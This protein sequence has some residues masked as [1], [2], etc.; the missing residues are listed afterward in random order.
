MKISDILKS[1]GANLLR[2]KG[3]TILTV[4][5]IFIGAFTISLTTGVNTGVNDYIDKQVSSVGGENQLFVQPKMETGMESS[6]GPAEYNPEQASA[7]MEYLSNRDLDK[8]KEKKGI[9][10]AE[11][12]MFLSTDYIQGTGDKK[13]VFSAATPSEI[14]IDLEAGKEVTSTG[15]AY[16]LNLAPEYLESLGYKKAQDAI[17][18]IVRIAV[19]SQATGEQEILEAKI[20]GVRTT[21]LIQGGQSIVSK[22]LGNRIAE[23]NEKG[24]PDAMKNQ[25]TAISAVTADGLSTEEVKEIQKKLEEDGYTAT[26]VEDEIGMI[27]DII[28]AITGVLTMFGAIALLAASFGIINTLYMSVQERTREIGLMK[29][30]GLSSGKVFMIFSVEAALI[31]F[32]G[33]VLGIAGAMGASVFI[34]QFAAKSFLDALTGFTLLQF[35]PIS[36]LSIIVIIMVIAFLAGTLPARRA[37]SLD[38]IESLR[39]E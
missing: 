4:V 22:A 24:L 36:S 19:S 25:Y 34:N 10:K 32:L 14:T 16:E 11:P 6:D 30:M 33:S 28:N 13:F 27:R 17:G 2:N 18:E 21:S 38:P 31:G 39:Y 8:V 23:I 12:F 1:A 37:A 20:I 26:T 15:E 3:R 5:A 35:S 7:E 9:K 29:A